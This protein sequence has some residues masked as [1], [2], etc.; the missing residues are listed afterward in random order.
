M[1]YQRKIVSELKARLALEP[2]FIQIVVGPRQVGKTTAVK[3]LEAEVDLPSIYGAAD[4]AG[5]ADQS[6]LSTKW[7]EARALLKNN[8]CALLVLDEVQL[9][10]EWQRVVKALWD[11][12]KDHTG[13]LHVIITG[14]SAL[15]LKKGSESLAGRFEVHNLLQWSFAEMRDAFGYSLEEFILQ[16]GYPATAGLRNDEV[17]WKDYI[18][19]SLIETV[20]SKDVIAL[21]QITKPALLKQLFVLACSYP[22]EIVAYTKFLGQLHDV[23]NVT[24]LSSYRQVLED[25]YLIKTL[26]KWSGSQ[27]KARASKPKWIIRDNSLI[28]ALAPYALQQIPEL[29]LYGRLLENAVISHLLKLVPEAYYWREKTNEVDLVFQYQGQLY[30]VEI[31][32]GTRTCSKSGLSAFQKRYPDSKVLLIGAGG[33]A[34]E[35]VLSAQ[36]W[37]W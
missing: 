16:G 7:A 32:A 33:I 34:I 36:S 8:G 30:G 37:V 27:I 20:L 35:D 4:T 13:K 14:S 26:N 17:R 15:L 28:T 22:A 5:A 10:P 31:K 12:E 23:G 18:K 24:T 1:K 2:Q 29:P 3:Q 21:S 19:A 9:V 11:Q 6:W 25:A